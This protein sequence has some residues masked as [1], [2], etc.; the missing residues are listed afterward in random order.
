MSK[1]IRL[2][3]LKRGN[4]IS[5]DKEFPVRLRKF[6]TMKQLFGTDPVRLLR[7]R[8][9]C[10]ATN[11]LVNFAGYTVASKIQDSQIRHIPK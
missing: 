7:D 5:P 10:E 8:S 3:V 1:A 11:V 2:D 4:E 6:S 9:L